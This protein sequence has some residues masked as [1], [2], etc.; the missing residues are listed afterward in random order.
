[1]SLDPCNENVPVLKDLDVAFCVAD[2]AIR[3]W[4]FTESCHGPL[5]LVHM[6][7][8]SGGVAVSRRNDSRIS[9]SRIIQKR[10]GEGSILIILVKNASIV[11]PGE[12]ESLELVVAMF[13]TRIT[14]HTPLDLAVPTVDAVDGIGVSA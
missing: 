6:D 14:A 7:D 8:I 9:P 5:L 10:H 3:F 2:P 1:M 11:L 12:G 4:V 13:L